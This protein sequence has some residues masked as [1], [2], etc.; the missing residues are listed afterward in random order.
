MDM[1]RGKGILKTGGGRAWKGPC[2]GA[3]RG[4]RGDAVCELKGCPRLRNTLRPQT[5]TYDLDHFDFF[6]EIP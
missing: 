3:M 5:L 2:G 6:K 1:G 4:R